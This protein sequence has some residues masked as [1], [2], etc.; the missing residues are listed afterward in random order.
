MRRPLVPLVVMFLLGIAAARLVVLRAPFLFLG[1]FL[2]AGLALL[3]AA[4]RRPLVSTAFLLLLFLVLGA[5]RLEVELRL[6]PSH[7][8]DRLPEEV[9]ERPLLIEGIIASPS[10]P[11]AGETRGPEGG[12]DRVRVLLDLHTIWLEGRQIDVKIGRASC[13]ERVYVLV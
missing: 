12:D 3:S 4:V 8:I 6:L 13:R 7:H 9:L 11:L 1:G 5:G 2:A 10:D